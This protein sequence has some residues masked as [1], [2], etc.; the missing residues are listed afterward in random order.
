MAVCA[1]DHARVL[2]VTSVGLLVRQLVPGVGSRQEVFWPNRSPG[3][4][5]LARQGG[6]AVGVLIGGNQL[7]RTGTEGRPTLLSGSQA[8][9]ETPVIV[10]GQVRDPR[11]G[12]YLGLTEEWRPARDR[13]GLFESRV[14][15]VPVSQLISRGQFVFDQLQTA[16]PARRP[17]LWF[18]AAG[19]ADSVRA[20]CAGVLNEEVAGRLVIREIVPVPGR[21]VS[22]RSASGGTLYGRSDDGQAAWGISFVGDSV[23]IAPVPIGSTEDAFEYGDRVILQLPEISWTSVTKYVWD[24]SAPFQT[25]PVGRSAFVSIDDG[26]AFGFDIFTTLSASSQRN[27]V[28]IGTWGGV[29]LCEFKPGEPLNFV[30]NG[31]NCRLTFDLGGDVR[32][33]GQLVDVS[34]LR[35]D[36]AGTLWAKFGTP[37]RI[38]SLTSGRWMPHETGW[39]LEAAA[40]GG[41]TVRVED[42]GVWINGTRYDKSLDAWGIG[43]RPLTG[44]IDLAWDPRRQI[45]WLCSREHG[46][47]KVR[48]RSRLFFQP[49]LRSEVPDTR[50]DSTGIGR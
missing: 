42:A 20:F 19:C 22:L 47:V 39:P 25:S 10:F 40:F 31:S 26:L 5:V 29:F 15:V 13:H 46:L 45:L 6:Q 34:R 35:R 36:E 32:S 33:R 44:I 27:E 14:P 18:T 17:G 7:V 41:F 1:L 9:E 38:A 24:S 43:V 50:R 16:A 4:C 12:R 30:V 21:I 11:A 2:M 49:G 23:N 37:T 28:A 8:S 48:L 3:R